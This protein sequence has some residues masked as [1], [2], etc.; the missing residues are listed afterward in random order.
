VSIKEKRKDTT[1]A[2]ILVLQIKALSYLTI[3]AK[4]KAMKVTGQN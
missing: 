4:I 2:V 3:I 1:I